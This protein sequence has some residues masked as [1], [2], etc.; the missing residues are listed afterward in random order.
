MTGSDA[1]DDGGTVPAEPPLEE[2]FARLR[3]RAERFRAWLDQLR[4][5]DPAFAEASILYPSDMS[6]WQSAV[7]LLTGCRE[8]WAALGAPVLAE[9]SI[10][11]VIHELERPRRAWSSSEHA[12]MEWAAHFWDVDR[13]AARFPYSL[14]RFYFYRWI[15][16]LHLR[17]RMPQ[18]LTGG[19]EVSG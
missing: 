9:R 1:V 17:Q 19:G 16:A 8:A 7:Y 6:E 12:V 2:V 4:A 15:T 13:H 3:D 11:P 14:E 5:G 18:D 10:A